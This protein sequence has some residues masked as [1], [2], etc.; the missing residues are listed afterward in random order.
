MTSWK[1]DRKKTAQ[2]KR[3]VPKMP[4]GYYSGDRP[5][6]NLRAFVEA[7]VAE[8]P[9]DPET[10]K[11][12][13]PPFDHPI[14][15]TKATAIYNMHTYWSKKP[16][17]AIRQYIRHYTKPGDLVL[18]P[19]C[20][21]GGTALAA[22]MEGR[23]AIAIDRSPAATFIT[24]NY[25]TPVDVD[26]LKAA[27]EDLKAKVKP[28]I[29]W[30][31]ETKCDRCGGKAT[32]AYTVYSQ[33][34]QCPRCMEKV[35][36]FDCPE[37]EGRTQKGKPKKIRVCP[38]CQKR[39][40]QEEIST[41]GEKFGA[42][43]VL[44]SY[45]C[46]N[47]CKPARDERRH[48]DL[49]PKKRE[50][51]ERYDLGKIREIEGKEIPHWYPPHKMMNVEDDSKPW[52]AE[53]R[54]GR[55]FR[56]VAELFTKRN[57]WALAAIRTNVQKHN[58]I[59]LAL[60]SI[61]LNS[62]NLYRHRTGGGGGSTGN[63]YIAPERREMAVWSQ[64]ED[65]VEEFSKASSSFNPTVFISTDS[66]TKMDS[67]PNSSI[68]YI[69]TDPPYAGKVQ[70]GEMNFV[71]E[72]WLRLDTGWH[73]E[74]IT[75]NEIRGK[76]EADW[77]NDMRKAM[78]ECFR[79]L[80]PG[81]AI[82][83]C[84]HDTSEG[85]WAL[86]QDIMAEAG[87]VAEKSGSALFIDTGQK[88]YNQLT[89]DKVNKRDLVI[90]FRKPKAGEIAGQIITEVDDFGTFQDKARN[91]IAA[92]LSSN[93][94]STKDRV[95]DDLVSRMVRRGKM[96]PHHFD[97]LLSQVA[98]PVYPEGQ[99]NGA[100]RWYLRDQGFEDSAESAKEDSAAAIVREFITKTKK[101]EDEGVHYSDIFE[102]YIYAIP[103]KEKPRRPLAEW[104]LDY[105]YKTD[106]GTY[107]LPSSPEEEQIKKEGRS[108]G[109]SRRIKRYL[110]YI[111]QGVPVPAGERPGDATLADWIRHAKRSGMYEQG[112]LLYEKGG[113]R[114]ENL[115]EEV[116]ANVDEDYQICVKM[117]A[118]RASPERDRLKKKR[119]KD[120]PDGQ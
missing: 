28:E 106:E 34:F 14:E 9:Y 41:S 58:H 45:I 26:E 96:E 31:Y 37:V 104:L 15:T 2:R 63:Y 120:I 56:T 20:G 46:E 11:Y 71:W 82:S 88:S 22:L 67:I 109:I 119:K 59:M 39:G 101:P 10:D 23:K 92:Y 74:E 68:D 27:F 6:P 118:R 105:F 65:K 51:F 73:N 25:C 32:T 91:I 7:H 80:K 111:D 78:S 52:G 35:A 102:H 5:N 62:S 4:E 3:P 77:A 84:Y 21:S 108:H 79:V 110:S 30:L 85:T 99:A 55:N 54:E 42:E 60:N 12:D 103:A 95:Y 33:V 115:S 47:G 113:L 83:L 87:F 18:D 40:I 116:Q 90:N 112:K 57:L 81:R 75:I 93:P 1:D 69:F 97:D 29:D 64:L 36:L 53:W 13:V 100:A 70:Y 17:D 19:F 49:D 107:R 98:E 114:L 43:P 44:V 24:K 50:F 86:V 89:A 66:A 8:R 16:H 94:G 48:D 72:A 38:H 61:I 76:T 117:L